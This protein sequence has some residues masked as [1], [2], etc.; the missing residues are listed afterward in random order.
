PVAPVTR[1]RLVMKSSMRYTANRSRTPRHITDQHVFGYR[2][3]NPM[4]FARFQLD[5]H[6]IGREFLK[7]VPL[8]GVT[9]HSGIGIILRGSHSFMVVSVRALDFRMWR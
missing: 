3:W 8:I 5:N 1:M 4:R 9:C 6:Q 2:Q 7:R